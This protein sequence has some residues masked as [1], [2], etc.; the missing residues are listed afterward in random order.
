LASFAAISTCL[1]STADVLLESPTREH[2]EADEDVVARVV[3]SDAAEVV[4]PTVVCIP[5]D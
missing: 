5:A 2:A 3:A 1:G 4:R